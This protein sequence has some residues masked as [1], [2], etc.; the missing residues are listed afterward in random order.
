MGDLPPFTAEEKKE[1]DLVPMTVSPSGRPLA[2]P[3]TAPAGISAVQPGTPTT[4]AP[5]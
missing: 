5:A 1:A 2:L 3:G 4:G